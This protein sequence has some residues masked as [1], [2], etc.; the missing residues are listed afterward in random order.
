MVRGK[1]AF[2]M[3]LAALMI[4]AQ[5]FFL[6]SCSGHIH[7]GRLI[8][9]STSSSPIPCCGAFQCDECSQ[10]YEASVKSSDIGIPV[11]NITGSL[12]EISKTTK[13]TVDVDYDGSISFNSAATLKWQG[14]STLRYPKKN[15]SLQFIKGSGKKNSVT[16]NDK[17]GSQSK[18]CLKANWGDFAGAHNLVAAKIWG[19]I[20]HSRDIDDELSPLVNGGGVDGYPVLLYLNGDFEGLYTLNIPKDK[21]L[22]GMSG[23]NEREGLLFGDEW[24]DSTLLRETVADVNAPSESGWDVEYCSTEKDAKTGTAWLISG[25]NGLISFLSDNDGEQLKEGLGAYTDVDRA[26]DYMLYILF[27]LGADNTGR[28]IL[29]ATWDGVKYLPCAYDMDNSWPAYEGTSSLSSSQMN[30]L[31]TAWTNGDALRGN[32]LFERLL[33]NYAN[34]T[35][36]RYKELRT[37]ALSYEN[38]ENRFKTYFEQIPD[39]AA[40]AER[41]R[42]NSQPGMDQDNE[43]GFMDFFTKRTEMLDEYFGVHI[44]E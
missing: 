24:S 2:C 9:L 28:N 6:V 12:E 29:W 21:W 37:G 10:E 39:I 14:S 33:D 17:W 34:E 19:D 30:E 41:E 26:I 1:K 32:L 23:K 36:K 4:S 16:L 42:W 44:P 22:L 5:A 15:Y 25:M 40:A 38:V 27:I 31:L 7:S 3:L 13:V 18:Y 8:A 20:V 11:I 35:A 43:S